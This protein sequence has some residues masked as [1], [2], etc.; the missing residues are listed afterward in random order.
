MPWA[1]ECDANNALSSCVINNVSQTEPLAQPI[2]SGITSSNVVRRTCAC[3]RCRQWRH[4]SSW[5]PSP[6]FCFR[7]PVTS[8][9]GWLPPG[10]LRRPITSAQRHREI[11]PSRCSTIIEW[12]LH[13]YANYYTVSQKKTSTSKI[14]FVVTTSNFHHIWQF[15]ARRWQTV[16]YEVHSF[17]ISL[18]SHQCTTL[19]NA[20]VQNCYV[21]L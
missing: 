2:G 1:G 8:A 13:K 3:F 11:C 15:L 18:N 7:L 17:S 6:C 10:T 12:A 4:W 5:R 16:L 9:A 14:I 21:M 20:D 19:L